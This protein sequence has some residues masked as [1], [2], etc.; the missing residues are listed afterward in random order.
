MA[1]MLRS[2]V[3]KL[4]VRDSGEIGVE[5]A[6]FPRM[7]PSLTETR[8]VADLEWLGRRRY[9]ATFRLGDQGGYG[10]LAALL[11]AV[12]GRR[13]TSISVGGSPGM[14]IMI[15]AMARCAATFAEAGVCGF[16]FSH[17][18]PARCRTCPMFDPERA[19]AT[20]ARSSSAGMT[21]TPSSDHER[22]S[23]PTT[24]EVIGPMGTSAT[25]ARPAVGRTNARGRRAQRLVP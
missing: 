8:L 4:A 1:S 16:A 20:I 9:R 12:G 19:Q 13:A 10:T 24:W 11:S 23:G 25:G 6:A 17:A 22:S 14:L 18:L 2:H 21:S 5:F 3:R 7:S 15:L